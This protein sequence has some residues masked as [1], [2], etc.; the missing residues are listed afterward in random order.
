MIPPEFGTRLKYAS[1]QLFNYIIIRIPP[2]CLKSKDEVIYVAEKYEH[3]SIIIFFKYQLN[4]K[5]LLVSVY[6]PF[7]SQSLLHA[8]ISL[9]MW[10]PFISR[11][12]IPR[13]PVCA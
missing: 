9:Q 5:H 2:A 6:G 13:P 12:Y 11:A 4:Y 8:G 10:S 1:T 3:L 7:P